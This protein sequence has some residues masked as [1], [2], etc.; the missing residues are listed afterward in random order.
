MSANKG[1]TDNE[2]WLGD[3]RCAISFSQGARCSSGYGDRAG[4]CWP[5]CFS[6]GLWNGRAYPI[7]LPLAQR[8]VEGPQGT[9]DDSLQGR[10]PGDQSH[11]EAKLQTL[12]DRRHGDRQTTSRRA[13]SIQEGGAVAPGRT[14]P[15]PVGGRSI[16]PLALAR[17]PGS[18][19]THG[20]EELGSEAQVVMQRQEGDPL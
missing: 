1:N 7:S 6:Q 14:P 19:G 10:V 20:V 17:A 15:Q 5:I 9:G 11:T 16:P 4:H 2:C 3:G 8:R 12:L 18:Q 13:A